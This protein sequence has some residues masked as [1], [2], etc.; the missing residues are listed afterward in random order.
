VR[1]AAG[2]V[3]LEPASFQ[4]LCRVRDVLCEGDAPPSLA[5]LAARMGVS[6]FHLTRQFAALY[7]AT[8]RQAQIEARL[9]R[10]RELL[11]R[12]EL[13][14]TE[15]CMEVGF[16]SLGSFSSLFSRRVGTTPSDFRRRARALAQV[17][18]AYP[19]AA[20]AGCYSLL[21]MLPATLTPHEWRS[22]GGA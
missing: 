12:G 10:A 17:P 16:S 11:A 4:R 22:A 19:A 14:V 7:G 8:P 5:A 18:A 21:A 15:V 9:A 13:S 6:R 2:R 20:H 3:F 1:H